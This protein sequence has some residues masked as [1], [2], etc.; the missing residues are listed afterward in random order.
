MKATLIQ[1]NLPN[2]KGAANLYRLDPPMVYAEW[3]YEDDTHIEKQ[4]EY[5]L[6]S[7][8]V[9][10]FEGPETYIFPADSEGN[11]TDFSEL[12]GSYRGG[13]NHKK[14]LRGAGYEMVNG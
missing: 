1:A 4:Y 7:A 14:A 13:L 11:V 9:V 12:P 6:V 10:P 3:R 5:V 2:Y 8:A